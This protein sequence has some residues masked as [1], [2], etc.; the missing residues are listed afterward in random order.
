MH[1][2]RIIDLIRAAIRDV[3]QFLDGLQPLVTH[4]TE[5]MWLVAPTA[6]S[7][8]APRMDARDAWWRRSSAVRHRVGGYARCWQKHRADGARPGRR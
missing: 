8:V 4:E 2:G 1:H 6:V 7:R 3:A 5:Q